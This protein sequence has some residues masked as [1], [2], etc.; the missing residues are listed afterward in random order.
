[1]EEKNSLVSQSCV[2]SDQ[3][4]DFT[5]FKSNSEVSKSISNISVENYFFLEKY[6]TS[7]GAISPNV[8]YY[9]QLPVTRYQVNFYAN[10]YFE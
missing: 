9:P 8:L 6:V 3:M 5:T 10:S 2:L 4:L 1:M 7:K